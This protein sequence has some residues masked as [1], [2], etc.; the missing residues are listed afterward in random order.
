MQQWFGDGTGDAVIASRVTQ[1]V[2]GTGVAAGRVWGAGSNGSGE[3]GLGDASTLTGALDLQQTEQAIDRPAIISAGASH[4]LALDAS[5][6]IWSWGFN[7]DGQ[8]GIGTVLQPGESAHHPYKV[9]K[10]GDAIAIA[11][12]TYHSLAV[13]VAGR[14][15]GW[16]NNDKGQLGD[17]TTTNRSTPTLVKGL[18][19]IVAVAAGLNFSLALG[20]DG[21]IRSWGANEHGEAVVADRRDRN[22]RRSVAQ[23]R[24]CCGRDG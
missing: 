24:S 2:R 6:S 13:D 20:V 3:L 15:W 11:G 18:P 10:I 14:V 12:G 1:T 4:S 21:Q 17:G 5:G 19:E 9:P 16:G 23:R 7:N 8:L 22:R